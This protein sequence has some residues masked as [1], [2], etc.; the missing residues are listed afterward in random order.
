MADGFHETL[1]EFSMS[2]ALPVL[3]QELHSMENCGC[4][5]NKYENKLNKSLL[6]W[7]LVDPLVGSYKVDQIMDPMSKLVSFRA[8]DLFGTIKTKYNLKYFVCSFVKKTSDLIPMVTIA[9]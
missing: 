8:F 7:P 2:E 1:Q 9:P 5:G 6:L 3:F 4:H